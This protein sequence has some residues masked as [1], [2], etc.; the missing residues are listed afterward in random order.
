MVTPPGTDMN[1]VSKVLQRHRRKVIPLNNRSIVSHLNHGESYFYPQG[2]TCDCG[3]ALGSLI[4]RS[5]AGRVEKRWLDDLRK[6][7]WSETKIARWGEQKKSIHKREERIQKLREEAR[8][9]DPDGWCAIIGELI[10]RAGIKYTG[11]FLHWYSGGLET[12]KLDQ[13]RRIELGLD[14]NLADALYHMEEDNLYVVAADPGKT[15]R[16]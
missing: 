4:H 2:S 5:D 14:E 12:E 13:P 10:E 1:A 8:G 9:S 7:G 11:L 6:K 15:S 3:T 16:H